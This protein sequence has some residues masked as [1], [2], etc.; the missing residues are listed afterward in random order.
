[1]KP[2]TRT[3]WLVLAGL[4]GGFFGFD[5]VYATLLNSLRGSHLLPLLIGPLLVGG[6]LAQL[7]LI[8]AWGA[9]APNHEIVRLWWVILLGLLTGTAL[10]LGAYGHAREFIVGLIEPTTVFGAILVAQV[11]LWIANRSF[12]HGLG[13]LVGCAATGGCQCFILCHFLGILFRMPSFMEALALSGSLFLINVAL[14][15]TVFCTLLVVRAL[16]FRLIRKPTRRAASL[17]HLAQND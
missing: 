6:L 7:M 11:S 8:A 3:T 9:L 17:A 15:L 2:S 16:G 5:L 10:S 14:G 1:M 13:W 12:R 4:I